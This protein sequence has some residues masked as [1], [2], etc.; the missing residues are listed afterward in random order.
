[1]TSG[2]RPGRFFPPLNTRGYHS[3][4]KNDDTTVSA[5]FLDQN[6]KEIEKEISEVVCTAQRQVIYYVDHL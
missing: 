1:M 4:E 3:K 2:G 5:Y 6:E